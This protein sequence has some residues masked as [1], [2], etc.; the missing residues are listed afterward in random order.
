MDQR[1]Q[2]DEFESMFRRAEREAFA[3]AELPLETVALV[4]D[5][6][7]G[8]SAAVREQLSV[9]L[10]KL[11]DVRTWHV[12]GQGDYNSVQSLIE[13]LGTQAPDL[14]VTYRHLFEE[15]LVPQHSLGVYLDVLTQVLSSPVL[16]LPGTAIDPSPIDGTPGRC[17]MAVTDH[18]AGDNRL[19]N[20]GA[21]M[22]PDGGEM[23]LCHVE[24]DAVFER[25]MRAIE[26]IPE[27]HTPQARTLIERQLLK[28]AGDFIET[29]LTELRPRRPD[30]AFHTSIGR[31]HRL[32]QYRQLVE[33]HD[34]DLLLVNTKDDDQ[35]A[36]HGMAYALSVELI[37]RMLLLL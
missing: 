32:R 23:W 3:F 12:N 24:D 5:Q 1:D 27:I 34:V 16:V 22:T 26:R 2:I 6:P 17:V 19:I 21:A 36:M 35:L 30:V 28:E 31:G 14:V 15:S 11:N 7:S 10:P 13:R 8:R 29:A 9:F 33:S 20:F 4:T 18:I 37:D 25:Y